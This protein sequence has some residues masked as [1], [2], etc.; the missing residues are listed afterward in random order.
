MLTFKLLR[1][2]FCFCRRLFSWTFA[3]SKFKLTHKNMYD[4]LICYLLNIHGNIGERLSN[5]NFNLF[6]PTRGRKITEITLEWDST[7]IV[8]LDYRCEK[9]LK[10]FE[11]YFLS[12]SMINWINNIFSTIL[13]SQRSPIIKAK[14]SDIPKSEFLFFVDV[15][16]LMYWTVLIFVLA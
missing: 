15:F 1:Q 8:C 6:S 13:S 4:P 10:T 3:L 14:Y 7:H 5:G 9:Y 12:I 2:G 11:R 16:F